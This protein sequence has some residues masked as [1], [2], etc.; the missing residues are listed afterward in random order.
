[1]DIH[2][3]INALQIGGSVKMRPDSILIRYTG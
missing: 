1:M 2:L 3:H